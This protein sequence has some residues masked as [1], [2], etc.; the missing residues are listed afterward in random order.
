VQVAPGPIGVTFDAIRSVVDPWL[1]DP[2]RILKEGRV[3]LLYR[4]Q[5]EGEHPRPMRLKIEINSREHFTEHG[6]VQSP[7]EI[8]SRWWAGGAQI[9]TFSLE[10]LLGTKLSTLF[11][12]K[13]RRDLFDVWHALKNGADSDKLVVCFNDMALGLRS[14][15]RR[16]AFYV[17]VVRGAKRC[18]RR[19]MPTMSRS[20]VTLSAES[21]ENSHALSDVISYLYTP[22]GWNSLNSPSGE[23]FDPYS[24]LRS[25]CEISRTIV[26]RSQLLA[27]VNRCR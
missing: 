10:D 5:S 6:H 15:C 18:I 14:C 4:F 1:G 21:L 17:Y 11:Q 16:E 26:Y 19:H 9:T 3:N 8:R 24:F 2:R 27:E 20:V 22:R 12:R 23:S 13:K 25:R 7:F